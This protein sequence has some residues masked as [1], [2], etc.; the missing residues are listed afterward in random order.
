MRF[1][2]VFLLVLD[3]VGVGETTDAINFNDNGANTLGHVNETCDL[4]IPN[5]KKNWFFRYIDY[6]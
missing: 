4:F 6:E 3:S 2:R 5:L 1:K